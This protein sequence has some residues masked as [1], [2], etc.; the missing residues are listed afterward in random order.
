M[1]RV[2]S[3]V[4]EKSPIFGKN[5]AIIRPL[6]KIPMMTVPVTAKD[7]IVNVAERNSFIE[8]LASGVLRFSSSRYV[9]KVGINATVM[10]FSAKMRLSRLGIIKATVKASAR[11]PVPRKADLVISRISPKTRDTRVSTDRLRPL[12]SKEDFRFIDYRFC[13]TRT[14]YRCPFR[15]LQ[16][17]GAFRAERFLQFSVVAVAICG[18]GH[19][20]YRY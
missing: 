5:T 4:A 1:M 9:W 12:L 6:H 18:A 14:F 8:T 20:R 13:F 10:L 16:K 11:G 15:K 3:T 17:R 7:S 2:K 19:L